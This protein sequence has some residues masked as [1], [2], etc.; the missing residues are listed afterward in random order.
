[1]NAATRLLKAAAD[2]E[3]AKPIG[4]FEHRLD[5]ERSIY[6]L[7]KR[8]AMENCGFLLQ[9]FSASELDKVKAATKDA[10]GDPRGVKNDLLLAFEI[11]KQLQVLSL[12]EPYRFSALEKVDRSAF[13]EFG[14][15]LRKWVLR[16]TAVE[17]VFTV[18]G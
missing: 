11:R 1:M 7:A 15:H 17:A 2:F 10:D 6:Y 12:S 4:G 5:I 13:I 16:L 9:G 14:R 8:Y 18:C 3:A